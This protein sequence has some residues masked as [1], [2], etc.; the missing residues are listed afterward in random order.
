MTV[1]P[2]QSFKLKL[3][4]SIL[5]SSFTAFLLIFSAAVYFTS[6]EIEESAANIVS[7]K[8]LMATRAI[9]DDLTDM[10]IS[11]HNMAGM[12]SSPYIK[13]ELKNAS[14]V[15]RG[16]L[17]SNPHVQGVCTGYEDGSIFN[18]PGPWC[19][20]V[21]RRGEE[22]IFND[23]SLKYDFQKADWYRIPF[24]TRKPY[25]TN[26]FVE[27]NGTIITSYNVPII[28]PRDNEVKCVLAVDLNLN[29]LSDSLKLLRPYKGSELYLISD[30]GCYIAHPERDSVMVAYASEELIEFAHSDE[31]I[32]LSKKGREK[33]YYFHSTVAKTGWEV[34]LSVPRSAFI[35]RSNRMLNIILIDMLIGLILLLLGAMY[36]I[37]KLTKP[38]ETFAEAARQI[39]HGDFKVDLPVITDNNELYDLRA[40]LA[41]MEVSLDRYMRELEETSSKKASIERELDIARS[42]QMAMIPKIFP[43]YPE[44]DNLDIYASLTPAQAVGG[45]LYDFVLLEDKFFFCVGDVSGKGV[46]ASLLMAITRTLF[47]NNATLDR[48]P[49]DIA[50]ILNNALTDGNDMGYFVTMMIGTI[51]LKTGECRI[52][53]CGHNLPVTNNPY[54]LC[55][56]PANIALGVV[57]GFEYKEVVSQMTP[58]SLLMLYTDG[59]TEA[60]NK[61][62]ELY[63]EKRLLSCLSAMDEG[64]NSK[65]IVDRLKADVNEFADGAQQSDDITLLCL[66]CNRL[67]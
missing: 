62:G 51:D 60:E 17:K 12:I 36:V 30:D 11:A 31:L 34:L 65:E 66:R 63:E 59:I 48:T 45:D 28:D 41:S 27:V 54:Q 53:N 56:L 23:I 67:G 29:E 57:L 10:E 22:F 4:L 8:L 25:W 5:C 40:A 37:N 19:P 9:D 32:Y 20:Y 52:C 7:S 35:D 26:P 14:A 21:M 13:F 49:A 43:P 50:R 58:G 16:F 44:R 2:R 24:E 1:N 33:V 46:P 15:C 64:C 3:I 6:Q 42:I 18:H 55:E 47:R 38:L 61:E 39:A